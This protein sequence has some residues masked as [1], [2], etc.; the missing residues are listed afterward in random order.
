MQIH[1]MNL[2]ELL[3][4]FTK[5]IISF[6]SVNINQTITDI[7]IH[8]NRIIVGRWIRFLPA[9]YINAW[10]TQRRVANKA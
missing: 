1:L 4:V 5:N 8:I 7:H 9:G 10:M 2:V 6:T 3:Y